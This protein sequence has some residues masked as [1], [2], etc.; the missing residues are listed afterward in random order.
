MLPHRVFR[1]YDYSVY[2]DGNVFITSDLSILTRTLDEY[3]I[4][5]H[6]HKNRD[7]VYEEVAACIAKKKDNIEK[8]KLHEQLLKKNGVPVHGGLLEA[9]VIARKHTD[10]RCIEVMEK[11]W[12]EFQEYSR[13]DQI[14]LIDCIW[15]LGLSVDTIAKL[16]DNIM[17]NDNFVII[18]HL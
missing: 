18:P 4:A 16:G 6:R 12:D 3:P 8:L 2:V 1:D 7:C 10:A 13:R 14:S 15:T 9:T 11:W 5:M 17:D